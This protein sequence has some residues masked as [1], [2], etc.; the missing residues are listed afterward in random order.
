MILPENCQEILEMRHRLIVCA[1]ALAGLVACGDDNNPSLID[2]AVHPDAG[3][4][5]ATAVET[6]PVNSTV[7]MSGLT[8]PVDVVFDTRGAP[9]IYGA[10]I[11]DVLRVQG[12]LMSRDRFPQ[13]EFIR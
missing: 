5:D 4:P 11:P 2:A 6:L 12:Y 9:H 13:M 10:T 7:T 3:T 8:G 1:A